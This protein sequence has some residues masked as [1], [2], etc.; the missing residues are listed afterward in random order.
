MYLGVDGGG[1][2]TAFCLLDE[3][4]VV[5][6]ETRE[7]SLYYFNEGI[8]LVESVLS[9]GVRAVCDT[10]GLTPESLAYSFIAIPCYG[11]ASADLPELDA[12]PG[13]VL[14]T[15]RY[16]C[17]NDMVCG[18]AGS[19]GGGDGINIVAGTGS[20]A[21]GERAGTRRRA[22]GWGELFGD[23]GS[24]YWVAIRGLNAFT[25]MSDGRLPTGPLLEALREALELSTDLDVI[26]IVLNR[27]K[28][29]RAKIADLSQVVASAADAGDAVAAEIL[30]CAGRELAQLLHVET[31][32]LGFAPGESIPVSYSGGMFTSWRVRES[33]AKAVAASPHAYDLRRPLLPPHVGAAIYAAHLAG[34]RFDAAQLH[35]LQ[36]ETNS[37]S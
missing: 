33:F 2:K 18:W 26:D 37:T 31:D 21:Y 6:A 5:A 11:E 30:R 24:G 17:G 25:R 35:H 16:A 9:R 8:G 4:G 32:A 29:D 15:D 23:E 3:D 27:W 19:L 10:A 12:I 20:I 7:Q 36:L 1:T 22:G 14:G 28:G 13:R 34:H